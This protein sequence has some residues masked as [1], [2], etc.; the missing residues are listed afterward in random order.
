MTRRIIESDF[1]YPGSGLNAGTAWVA[2]GVTL[3]APAEH[4]FTI[5]SGSVQLLVEGAVSA[6]FTYSGIVVSSSGHSLAVASGGLVRGAVAGVRF[7]AG[8]GAVITNHG[9]IFG[10]TAPAIDST[11]G[12]E[13]QLSN[14]G[15]IQGDN[16]GAFLRGGL[17]H[18]NHGT[19]LGRTALQLATTTEGGTNFINWGT[20]SGWGGVAVDGDG[21]DPDR[22][23]NYG[24]ISGAVAL[25]GGDDVLVNSGTISG[26]VDLATGN[27]LLDSR[28]GTIH[29]D[30]FLG[31]G[32]DTLDARGADIRGLVWGG[33]GS[34]TYI[35][36]DA[37]IQI[38]EEAG[39]GA[40]VVRSAVDYFLGPHLDSLVLIGDATTGV[41]NALANFVIGNVRA[42]VLSGMGGNDSIIGGNGDDTLRG[43]AGNDTVQGGDEDDF[44]AGGDGNDSLVGGDGNDF[45]QGGAGVDRIF[46]GL[47][48]DVL[49]GN[50]GADLLAGGA[51]ADTLTGGPGAD[52]FD[53]DSITDS[54][55]G[56]A[57]LIT[58]FQRGT[59]KIDLSTID[60]NGPLTGNGAFVFIGT[61][62]FTASGQVR[63]VDLGDDLL[64]QV[65]LDANRTPEMEILLTGVAT[66]VAAD[67]VL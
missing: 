39:F 11:N 33:S 32:N 15:L 25:R 1:N 22:L 18:E 64:L 48:D 14:F 26:S 13:V 67:I 7:D 51:G 56:E 55:T 34:D 16:L 17:L 38:V 46:G 42:N 24:E 4:V 43:G 20:L 45:L 35:V 6:G 8:G 37:D 30:I 3:F 29:L 66:L 10:S 47:D 5:N 50:G 23:R 19:I 54:A 49:R 36:D 12:V 58:D 57:D 60:A 65:N 44:I 31:D 59:D 62:A 27:D 21:G 28:G 9:V 40:D 53:F 61:D 41:G 63:I 2:R 52:V